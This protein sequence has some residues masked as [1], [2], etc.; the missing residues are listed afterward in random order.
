MQVSILKRSFVTLGILV[1]TGM[2]FAND[3]N[4]KSF[5]KNIVIALQ[6]ENPG[7]QQS[8]MQMV[9]KYGDRLNVKDAVFDVMRVF[10]NHPNTR[11][12]RLALITLTKM[13]S[14]WANYFLTRQIRFEKVASIKRQL[15]SHYLSKNRKTKSIAAGYEKPRPEDVALL[16]NLMSEQ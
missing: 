11:V 6:S 14:N 9:I 7:L 3:T 13:N 8:A 16:N 12:R 5:S 2:T 15:I 4:W 10:R 1:L